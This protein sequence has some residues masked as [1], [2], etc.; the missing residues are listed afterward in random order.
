MSGEPPSVFASAG[1]LAGTEID[2]LLR[3]AAQDDVGS[4]V[5]LGE[6]ADGSNVELN[7]DLDPLVEIGVFDGLLDVLRSYRLTPRVAVSKLA[8][9]RKR[10]IDSRE[11]R[12]EKGVAAVIRQATGTGRKPL[13]S[14]GEHWSRAHETDRDGRDERAVL[15]LRL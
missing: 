13:L 5:A 10:G 3:N 1:P 14:V 8:L 2:H 12:V 11:V 7:E 15:P 6:H 9:K 4:R